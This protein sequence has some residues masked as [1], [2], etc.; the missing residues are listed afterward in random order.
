M[1]VLY[2]T[3]LLCAKLTSMHKHLIP[4]K[5]K[6]T[7]IYIHYT[8]IGHGLCLIVHSV[9]LANVYIRVLTLHINAPHKVYIYNAILCTD[10]TYDSIVTLTKVSSKILTGN[11]ENVI[12]Q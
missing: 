11:K 3:D 10:I 1:H 12:N 2:Y 6:T 8:K 4:P 5:I 7:I 9:S